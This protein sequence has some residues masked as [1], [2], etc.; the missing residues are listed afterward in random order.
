MKGERRFWVLGEGLKAKGERL[1]AKAV[2]GF[3]CWVLGGRVKGKR[4]FECWV[5]GVGLRAK[6]ER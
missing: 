3:E 5:L 2:L 4:S 1:K 6:G